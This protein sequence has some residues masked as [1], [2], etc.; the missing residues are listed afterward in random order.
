[1]K[2]IRRAFVR[3]SRQKQT[4]AGYLKNANRPP[5]RSISGNDVK[6]KRNDGTASSGKPAVLSRSRA[7]AAINSVS[8][9]SRAADASSDVAKINQANMFSGEPLKSDTIST[10]TGRMPKSEKIGRRRTSRASDAS[11]KRR[12]ASAV[13]CACR[14]RFRARLFLGGSPILRVS[15][16]D[17]LQKVQCSLWVRSGHW[18]RN[19]AVLINARGY[20]A[21]GRRNEAPRPSATHLRRV[22]GVRW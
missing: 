7:R 20:F 6:S 3:L 22:T 19:Y 18:C 11:L 8:F 21:C 4:I 10:S 13:S 12:S 2:P 5:R 1:V 17:A 16:R 15:L 14:S 9:G